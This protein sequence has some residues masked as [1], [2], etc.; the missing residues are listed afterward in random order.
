MPIY[1]PQQMYYPAAAGPTSNPSIYV[2]PPTRTT[3]YPAPPNPARTTY[4]TVPPAPA[5]IPNPGVFQ[6]PAPGNRRGAAAADP[7]PRPGPLAAR[8]NRGA[9]APPVSSTFRLVYSL[10]KKL[11]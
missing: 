4:Y 3:H 5:P 7:W 9:G 8:S 11:E 1:Y 6:Q 10:A 2:F